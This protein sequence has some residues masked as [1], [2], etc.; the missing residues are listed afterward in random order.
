MSDTTPWIVVWAFGP[1]EGQQVSGPYDTRA[2]AADYD[3]T[4]D[5]LE[6]RQVS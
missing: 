4:D 5:R 1:K 6:V 3:P 2:E